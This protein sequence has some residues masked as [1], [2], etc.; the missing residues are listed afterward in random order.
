LEPG[1]ISVVRRLALLI[2][3]QLARVLQAIEAAVMGG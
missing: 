1:G 2:G 3:S